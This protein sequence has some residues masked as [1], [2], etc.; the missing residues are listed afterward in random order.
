MLLCSLNPL[1]EGIGYLAAAGSSR[2]DHGSS[3]VSGEMPEAEGGRRGIPKFATV[4]AYFGWGLL[5]GRWF[6]TLPV[7]SEASSAKQHQQDAGSHLIGRGIRRDV[8]GELR[9]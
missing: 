2:Q 9:L 7:F 3:E 1:F 6:F 5:A 8:R 4:V